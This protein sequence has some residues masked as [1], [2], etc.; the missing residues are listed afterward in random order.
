M[1]RINKGNLY[2]VG[3]LLHL[4][5]VVPLAKKRGKMYSYGNVAHTATTQI[6]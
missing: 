3:T 5:L 4:H 6:S 2:T 1:T